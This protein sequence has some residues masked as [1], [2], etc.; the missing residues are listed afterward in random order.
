MVTHRYLLLVGEETIKDR[1]AVT[2]HRHFQAILVL[3][4]LEQTLQA[5]VGTVHLEAIPGRPLPLLGSQEDT[6][7]ADGQNTNY[8]L[9][10]SPP[11]LLITFAL[12]APA[13]SHSH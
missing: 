9:P 12:L 10:V 5:H 1:H 2:E 11:L 3:H 13:P 8:F 7:L 6:G 4:Y